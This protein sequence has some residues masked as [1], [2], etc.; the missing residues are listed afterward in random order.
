LGLPQASAAN[1]KQVA[2]SQDGRTLYIDT[3]S[4]SGETNGPK[5]AWIKRQYNPQECTSDFAKL[6]KKCIVSSSTYERYYKDKSVCILQ[7]V[8]YF[9]DG[10]SYG[11]DPLSCTPRKI[12]PE[13]VSEVIWEYLY[14]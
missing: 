11:G 9:A 8:H 1:W 3:T 7:A 2:K 6:M 4:I 10:T 14:R 12:V 13:S 5:E